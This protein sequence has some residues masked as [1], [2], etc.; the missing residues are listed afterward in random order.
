MSFLECNEKNLKKTYDCVL[1][2]MSPQFIK[3]A[4]YHMATGVYH[5]HCAGFV[6]RDIKPANYLV[7]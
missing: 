7:K 6:H 2:L 3:T 5:L 1:Y 4:F